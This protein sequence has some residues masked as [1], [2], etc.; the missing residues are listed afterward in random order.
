MI[1]GGSFL[2]YSVLA[3]DPIAGQHLGILIIELGVGLTVASVMIIIFF[4][5]SA[6]REYQQANKGASL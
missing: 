5:F 1:N 2:D 6:R 4:S 3:A